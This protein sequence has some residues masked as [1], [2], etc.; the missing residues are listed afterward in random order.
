MCAY[1]CMISMAASEKECPVEGG[2]R[3]GE[4][5]MRAGCRGKSA[6]KEQDRAAYALVIIVIIIICQT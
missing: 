5:R 1:A 2:A 6:S 3:I 4:N